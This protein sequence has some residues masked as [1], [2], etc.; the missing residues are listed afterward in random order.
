MSLG[1]PRRSERPLRLAVTGCNG[2]VA[3]ALRDRA[4]PELQILPVGRPNLDLS[5]P[6]RSV[7]LFSELRPDAIVNAAAY[8]A[9]DKAETEKELALAINAAGAGAVAGAAAAL[10]IPVIQLST[11]YVFD[12]TATR[13]YRENDPTG[14]V[15]Y[16]G[17]SKLAGELAVRAATSNHVILRTSWVYAPYGSNFL[18]TMQRLAADRAEI[19]VVADQIGAPTSALEIAAAVERIARNLIRFPDDDRLRGIFHFTNR[20]ETSWAGFAREI[21]D[22]SA[23]LGVPS[24]RVIPIATADY[25]TAA[26]RPASSRLALDKIDAEHGIA[27]RYWSEAL[28]NVIAALATT[29]HLASHD[30]PGC[31]KGEI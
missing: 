27:P 23:S 14:P 10:D 26:R 19:R 2:Q 3:R 24:P 12:G 18:L 5:A 20:G 29:S 30:R 22:L 7:A 11:D 25:P 15:N 4:S 17:A 6:D 16:Y 31:S 8:T 9:V 28:C 21:F 1:S 13:P